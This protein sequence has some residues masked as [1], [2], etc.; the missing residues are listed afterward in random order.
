[1]DFQYVIKKL[2][3]VAI[4]QSNNITSTIPA[5]LAEDSVIIQPLA[6][7]PVYTSSCL[8][9]RPVILPCSSLSLQ[10]MKPIYSQAIDIDD[11]DYL[12]DF[13]QKTYVSDLDKE[14]N[15]WLSGC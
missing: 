14:R 7:L 9:T 3:A 6:A 8:I 4:G 12:D 1:M 13:N 10:D 2:T 15:M 5:T 11:F